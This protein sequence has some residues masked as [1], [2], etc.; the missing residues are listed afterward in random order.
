VID[1]SYLSQ[2]RDW[3]KTVHRPLDQRDDA[4]GIG[5]FELAHTLDCLLAGFVR[6]VG[7]M[8]LS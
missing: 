2:S 6:L 3:K 4:P 8:Q 5:P 1:A 7:W